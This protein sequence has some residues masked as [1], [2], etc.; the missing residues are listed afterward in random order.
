MTSILTETQDILP[1]HEVVGFDDRIEVN[2]NINVNDTLYKGVMEFHYA[3]DGATERLT[4]EA[5]KKVVD[6]YVEIETA[7]IRGELDEY[8]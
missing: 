6:R 5:I 8:I 7:G 2:L 3:K 1:E 4:A